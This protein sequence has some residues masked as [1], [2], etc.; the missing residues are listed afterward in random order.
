[1]YAP[2]AGGRVERLE[3]LA[4]APERQGCSLVRVLLTAVVR[5]FE[6]TDDLVDGAEGAADAGRA[7]LQRV[8]DQDQ[9]GAGACSLLDDQAHHP[10]IGHGRLVDDEDVDAGQARAAADALM[11][12]GY[13]APSDSAPSVR[14]VRAAVRA[15]R[16]P[17]RR[18]RPFTP[19]MRV[20]RWIG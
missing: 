2:D 19:F 15:G 9:L 10:S 14:P 6:P 4:L 1:M 18:I 7:Q 20:L 5:E 8:A 13:R 3:L 17:L 16:H 12:A 11:P